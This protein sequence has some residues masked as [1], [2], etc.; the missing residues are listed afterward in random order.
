MELPVAYYDG[1]APRLLIALVASRRRSSRSYRKTLAGNATRFSFKNHWYKIGN[2][3]SHFS[4]GAHS[5]QQHSSGLEW[6]DAT[7]SSSTTTTWKVKPPQKHKMTCASLP[8][9]LTSHLAL[10]STLFLPTCSGSP[11]ATTWVMK[12]GRVHLRRQTNK[13]TH[14]EHKGIVSLPTRDAVEIR[15][16]KRRTVSFLLTCPA[17][18]PLPSPSYHTPL[19]SSDTRR[20]DGKTPNS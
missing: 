9:A 13:K 2:H 11:P 10:R 6:L 3:S 15:R 1:T 14:G 5:P 19:Y 8:L 7:A 16:G 12:S 18:A 4:R 20:E 17:R